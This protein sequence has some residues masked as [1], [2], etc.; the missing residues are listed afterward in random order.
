M[1]HYYDEDV[2]HAEPVDGVDALTGGGGTH[3][4]RRGGILVGSNFD[5]GGCSFW[6]R[7]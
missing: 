6:D 3:R 2:V 4:T 5:I 1:T 7:D